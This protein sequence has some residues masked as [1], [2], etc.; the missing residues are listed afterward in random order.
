MEELLA[1]IEELKKEIA[2][3]KENKKEEPEVEEKEEPE[4]EEKEEKEEKEETDV[5]VEALEE[6]L[7]NYIDDKIA[8]F[9]EGFLATGNKKTV[10]KT[11]SNKE[12]LLK[13]FK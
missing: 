12:K 13:L 2:S 7:S 5:E 4:A 3:L 8:E 9:F 1:Q 11:K 10:E 6:R